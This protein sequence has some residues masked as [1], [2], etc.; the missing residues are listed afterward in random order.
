MSNLKNFDH[1]IFDLGNVLFK[2]QPNELAYSL[3]HP[4]LIEVV[5]SHH[6]KEF[7]RGTLNKEDLI[8]S[9][10]HKFPLIGHFLDR[11]EDFLKPI[12]ESLDLFYQCQKAGYSLYILS[13][14]PTFFRE[15]LVRRYPFL[16]EFHG[17][18]YSC[19]VG[20][21]KPEAEIYTCLLN[22][23]SLDPE[24]CLFL[25]DLEENIQ[26]AKTHG[27]QGIVFDGAENCLQQLQA[28]KVFK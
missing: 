19:D 18:I 9:V 11:A 27:I 25:D 10:S 13:N 1:I 23:F 8:N 20:Y 16:S 28:L 3:A 2:W 17:A 21:I 6:W 14:M 4:E 15:F 12:P 24:R 7:D 5:R 26:S 22:K